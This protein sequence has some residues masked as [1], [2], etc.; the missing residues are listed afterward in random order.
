MSTAVSRM[1]RWGA[2]VATAAVALFAGVGT[3]AAEAYP[4]VVPAVAGVSFGATAGIS[5]DGDTRALPITGADGTEAWVRVGAGAVL[6]GGI[7]VAGAS[8]RRRHLI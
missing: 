8:R 2:A 3:V 7:L 5:A 4:P 1:G 6:V